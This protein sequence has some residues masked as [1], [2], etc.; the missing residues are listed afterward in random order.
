MHAP[1]LELVRRFASIVAV[2]AMAS[3]LALAQDE[4]EIDALEEA[5][6]QFKNAMQRMMVPRSRMAAGPHVKAAFRDVVKDAAEGTVEVR[7][8]D[9]RLAYGVVVDAEGFVLT[10]FHLIEDASN[11]QCKLNDGR[12]V[13]A[14]LLGVAEAHDLA[15]L[16]LEAADLPTPHWS[17]ETYPQ[18]GSWVASVGTG[19][20]PLAVGIV[21]V[22]QRKIAKRSGLLGI[23]LGPGKEGGA[24]IEVLA[25]SAA[26]EAGL[27][28]GDVVTYI[29][30]KRTK[31]HAQVVAA[32]RKFG[33]GEEIE[34]TAMREGEQKKFNA[35]LTGSVK[36]LMRGPGELQ[37]KMGSK[38]SQRRSGFPAVLQHDSVL[39]A[40]ECGGALVNLDGKV[41]GVNVARAGRTESYA[42]PTAVI[43]TVLDDL[44]S[45]KLAP[46]EQNAASRLQ[47]LPEVGRPP[48]PVE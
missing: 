18:V 9:K 17:E 39:Q 20:D 11:L 44:K 16:K 7:S 30:E 38:L 2:V 4:G 13:S 1:L 27:K 32:V 23:R 47:E 29:N 5:R 15:M 21:S 48:E 41:V 42:I 46:P 22:P 6:S 40:D 33:P 28:K 12:K 10:K 8:G 31:T 36:G 14:T 37:N 34:I 25:E 19:R 3:S 43:L 45:G 26:K 24:I 35:T